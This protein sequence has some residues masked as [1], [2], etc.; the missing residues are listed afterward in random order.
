MPRLLL[1]TND[2]P[3]TVG[4]IQS[5]LRDFVALLPPEDVVVFAST[6]DPVAAREFDKSVP[7]KVVRYS[8]KLML[9]TPQV[10]KL[11]VDLIKSEGVSTVWFGAAAPLAVMAPAARAAGAIQIISTTHGHEVGWSMVPGARSVLRFIGQHSDVVTYISDYTLRRF[12]RAFGEHPKFVHLPSGV[13]VERFYPVDEKQ[14]FELRDQ[15]G[16]AEKDKVIVC[17]SRLVPRKGQ[18]TLIKAFPEVVQRC[19]EARLVIVGEGRIEGKLR[20]LAARDQ[21]ASSRISFEGRVSEEKMGMML[22]GADVFAMPCRTRGGGLDVE[23]LGIVFLEAQACGIPVIA[24]DSG[25]A[26]ETVTPATGVVVNGR[27]SSGVA[28]VIV[29]LVQQPAALMSMGH[30]G[31]QHVVDHWT[32]EIMGARLKSLIL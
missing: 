6:Q 26:P 23:G 32:W 10:K 4:G 2:F 5:Y 14:K 12:R 29:D 15:L 3:P 13:D 18:D 25:G 8:S 19:S 28:H 20:R 7:Y 1:V 17:T 22:R 21:K 9:P 11:M 24:G 16:W 27:D 31:R 30:A